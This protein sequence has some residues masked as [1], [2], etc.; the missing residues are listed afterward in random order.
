MTASNR[1]LMRPDLEHT[2]DDH[3][4]ARIAG[5][6]R[7][8]FTALFRRR[9]ADVYRFA[10]HVTGS[11]ALAEDVAQD[12]FLIVMRDAHRYQP[13]R[14]TVPAW[15]CGIARNCARQRLERDRRLEALDEGFADDGAAA[16]IEPDPLGDL[17]R[18]AGESP[19]CAGPYWPCRCDTAR[20]WCCAICRSSRTWR[21]PTR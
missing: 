6:E 17:A 9:Q 2:S 18:G 11:P 14:S 16:A 10:L 20:S 21:L 15:L 1:H 12:V 3:L 8:A 19:A 13:G 4:I 7:D 5:G